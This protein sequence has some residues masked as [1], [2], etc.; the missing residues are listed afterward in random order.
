MTI[1]LRELPFINKTLKDSMNLTIWSFQLLTDSYSKALLVY[2][3]KSAANIS[4]MNRN[5]T[6]C[7]ESD[8]CQK[9]T[10]QLV[11]SCF[12]SRISLASLF[13]LDLLQCAYW[14]QILHISGGNQQQNSHIL[15]PMKLASHMEHL[16]LL[17]LQRIHLVMFCRLVLLLISPDM[18]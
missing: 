17:L 5:K 2:R 4:E 15:Q 8:G 10:F 18:H 3:V 14:Q 9:K 7:N 1:L 16:L 6:T 12:L 13:P 11:F